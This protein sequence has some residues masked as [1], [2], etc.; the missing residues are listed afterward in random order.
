MIE[1]VARRSERES[2]DLDVS[3]ATGQVLEMRRDLRPRR[4]IPGCPRVR[5]RIVISLCGF[6]INRRDDAPRGAP[7]STDCRTRV[8]DV[9]FVRRR[10]E[11]RYGRALGGIP[12][13]RERA[14]LFGSLSGPVVASSRV[15]TIYALSSV[16]LD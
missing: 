12:R 8:Q 10:L 7:G 14:S 11:N 2:A 5:E 6:W 3:H 16:S 15:Y 9:A 1:R 4:D 13:G